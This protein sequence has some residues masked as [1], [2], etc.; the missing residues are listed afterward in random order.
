MC[1]VVSLA[2]DRF[3]FGRNMDI[4]GSFGEAV[5]FTPRH[6]ALD[7]RRAPKIKTHYAILGM[8]AIMDGFP[9][10]ADAMNE[11]GLCMAGL[12]FVGNAYYPPDREV[13]GWRISPFELIPWL[14]STCT[15]LAA[16]RRAL[17]ALQLVNVPFRQDVPLTPLHWIVADKTGS[18]VIESTS[19]G[20]F[21]YDDPEG[22]LANNPPFDRQLAGIRAYEALTPAYRP[23]DPFV[24]LGLGAVGLPGDYSSASRF[25]RACF[26]R[27]CALSSGATSLH[28]MYRI[29]DSV[30]PPKGS[31]LAENGMLHYTTYSCCMDPQAQIYT[32]TTA[33][34]RRITAVRMSGAIMESDR[35]L[36]SSLRVTSDVWE[37]VLEG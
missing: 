19:E 8:A 25:A 36:A 3:Y 17:N 37:S 6:F 18:L 27:R 4:E 24:S 9:L 7:L 2:G 30:A 5:V 23:T 32:Y 10:Y 20:L 16:A 22:V 13:D 1:T 34:N 15:D 29:L 14:L 11:C 31:V 35:L 21:L 28:D 26:L 33:E 12:N